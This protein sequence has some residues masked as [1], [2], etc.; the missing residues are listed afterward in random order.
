MLKKRISA[1]ILCLTMMTT[2][3]FP[4]MANA[5]TKVVPD[6]IYQGTAGWIALVQQQEDSNDGIAQ[7]EVTGDEFIIKIKTANNKTATIS[8]KTSEIVTNDQWGGL[9][10][11]RCQYSDQTGTYEATTNMRFSYENGTITTGG[12]E[13]WAMNQEGNDQTDPY[14]ACFH[15][16]EV[17]SSQ[18]L[19]KAFSIET[20]TSSTGEY[21]VMIAGRLKAD[22]VP[23]KNIIS[24]ADINKMA[25]SVIVY[26]TKTDEERIQVASTIEGMEITVSGGDITTATISGRVM[27]SKGKL[28]RYTTTVNF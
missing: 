8:T 19:T 17:S 7:I 3:L 28:D 26:N 6:G 11:L 25:I 14:L 9:F 2:A 24:Q 13:I 18:R 12:G 23:G 21:E 5:A 22:L 15:N 16:I 10:D 20:F 27:T 1:A 4:T